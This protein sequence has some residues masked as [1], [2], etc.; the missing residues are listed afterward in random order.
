[1]RR[2]TTLYKQKKYKEA[3]ELL[4]LAPHHYTYFNRGFEQTLLKVKCISKLG[5]LD[6][7][8]DALSR[9]LL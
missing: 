3:L 8:I 6:E 1:M 2:C 7:A 5:E 9:F 4:S